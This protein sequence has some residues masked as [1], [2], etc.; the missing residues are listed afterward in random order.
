MTINRLN[1]GVTNQV[2]VKAVSGQTTPLLELQDST[3]A[4]VSSIGPTGALGGT[5][6][7]SGLV[8]IE[9]Q[10]FSGVSGQIFNTSSLYKSYLLIINDLVC[11]TTQVNILLR[12]RNSGGDITGSFY[13]WAY[14]RTNAATS[15]VSGTGGSDESSARF[16]ISGN[17]SPSATSASFTFNNMSGVDIRPSY[18]G[19]AVANDGSVGVFQYASSGIYQSN[20]TPTGFSILTSTGTMSGTAKLYGYKD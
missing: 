20:I 7:N 3:G 6:G 4:V 5:L 16:F 2:L 19:T 10:T 12:F 8:H 9:T 18:T 17:I 14:S 1:Q 11:S 15:T 13:R